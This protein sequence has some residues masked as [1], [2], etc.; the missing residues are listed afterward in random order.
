MNVDETALQMSL[1]ELGPLEVHQVRRTPEEALFNNLIHHHHYR[2]YTQPV[3]EHLKYLVYAQGRPVAGIGFSNALFS[4][5]R[6]PEYGRTGAAHSA[7]RA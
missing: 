2:G 5:P 1:G 6:H 4:C 7:R 3:G